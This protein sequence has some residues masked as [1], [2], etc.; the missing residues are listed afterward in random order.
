MEEELIIIRKSK[1]K[2][3]AQK[4]IGRLYNIYIGT[5]RETTL[6]WRR[7]FSTESRIRFLLNSDAIV[8]FLN[9]LLFAFIGRVFG[10]TIGMI[11]LNFCLINILLFLFNKMGWIDKLLGEEKGENDE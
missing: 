4:V 11:L 2:R 7:V 10:G 9:T 1:L 5:M 3:L 8:L 6:F